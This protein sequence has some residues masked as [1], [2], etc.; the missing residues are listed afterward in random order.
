MLLFGGGIDFV[1]AARR[2]AASLWNPTGNNFNSPGNW[3]PAAADGVDLILDGT[4][5]AQLDDTCS[6]TPNNLTIGSSANGWLDINDGGS[7][8]LAGMMELGP[9]A[10]NAT[11]NMSG[12]AQLSIGNLKANLA[13]TGGGIS[14]FI[15]S[16]TSGATVRNTSTLTLFES[17]R[18]IELAIEGRLHLQRE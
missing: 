9:V 12:N 13:D 8:T 14:N 2:Q 3:N 7:L 17:L 5:A 6:F 4:V 15:M 10:S 16:G 1:P 18:T 11:V